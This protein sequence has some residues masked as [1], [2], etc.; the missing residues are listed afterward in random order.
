LPLRGLVVHATCILYVLHDTFKF[1]ENQMRHEEWVHCLQNRVFEISLKIFAVKD[2]NIYF[3][4]K[5]TNLI[6]VLPQKM[7]SRTITY[8]LK[9]ITSKLF[10]HEVK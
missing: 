9:L 6:L 10:H 1:K 8:P 2:L 7:I 4:A 5:E 3:D